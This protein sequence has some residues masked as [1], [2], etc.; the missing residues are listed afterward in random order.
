MANNLENLLRLNRTPAMPRGSNRLAGVVEPAMT[1]GSTVLAEIPAYVA[2]MAELNESG[3]P[4]EGVRRAEEVS[5]ML[6]YNPRTMEGKAG[7][8]SLTNGVMKVMDALGVD[9][10]VNYLNNTVVPRIQQT[11]G[12]TAAREIGSSVMMSLPFVRKVPGIQAFHGSPHDFDEFSMDAIGTGEGAQAYGHGLYF[13]GNKDVAQGYR[14]NIGRFRNR[15]YKGSFQA[16]L[17]TSS[18]ELPEQQAIN[19]VFSV[20]ESSGLPAERVIG[21][22]KKRLQS[23]IETYKKD[24]N[25]NKGDRLISMLLEDDQSFLN[26]IENLNPEDFKLT[27]GRMYEVEINATPDEFLDWDLPLSEQS[28]GVRN[29]IGRDDKWTTGESFYHLKSGAVDDQLND[30]AGEL[31]D[32]AAQSPNFDVDERGFPHRQVVSEYLKSKGIKGIRYKDGF[33]RGADG[34]TSN[35][36]IFDDRLISIAKKYGIA[37]PAAAALL[38]QETG[39]NPSSLYEEENPV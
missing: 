34:G 16:D 28:D 31:Y 8:Q 12:E 37:I 5:E 13:A 20:M 19:T 30:K 6:T 9:E 18:F 1:A 25:V 2:G 23:D 32:Y 3:L 15:E 22:Q 14:D 21:S 33:S 26:E 36:V 4:S 38:S 39:L 29:A 17:D 24:L 27:K 35:Y 7:L 11:F 10:A